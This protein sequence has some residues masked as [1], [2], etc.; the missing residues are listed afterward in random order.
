MFCDR[1]RKRLDSYWTAISF[2]DLIRPYY[3]AI[4]YPD[5]LN[6][7]AG[8]AFNS[9]AI[10]KKAARNLAGPGLLF[11]GHGRGLENVIGDPLVQHNRRGCTLLVQGRRQGNGKI[12]IGLHK[13]SWR[14]R[15]SR[16]FNV[17]R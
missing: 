13:D 1:F 4:A 3:G 17:E 8:S 7:Y 14:S 11:R 5:E 16:R 15:G 12:L 6:R 9:Y 2:S 10:G